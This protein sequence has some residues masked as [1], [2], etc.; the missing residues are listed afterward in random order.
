[1]ASHMLGADNPS[2][3]HG[4]HGIPE[5]AIWKAMRQ[6]CLN[7]NDK[8]YCD[9]GGRGIRVCDQWSDFGVFIADVGF[10]PSPIY[11]LDRVDNNGHYEPGNV[12]WALG[13]EQNLNKRKYKSNPNGLRNITLAGSKFWVQ[14]RR[15]G[16]RVFNARLSTLELA[17][18]A[19]D[20]FLASIGE[21][22][23]PIS[24]ASKLN[25][26]HSVTTTSE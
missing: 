21:E 15:G 20:D 19:R 4:L 10:R 13:S 8:R 7:P 2:F 17:V 3:R 22:Q 9:W 23:R 16:D 25:T 24:G 5:Y 18:V 11:S 12:R 14:I 1:M 26:A 6:R